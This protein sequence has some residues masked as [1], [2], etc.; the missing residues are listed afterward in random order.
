MSHVCKKNYV[1]DFGEGESVFKLAEKKS[2]QL[3]DVVVQFLI[4]NINLQCYS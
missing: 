2:N 3:V 4:I 1:W